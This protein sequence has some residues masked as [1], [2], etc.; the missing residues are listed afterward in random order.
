MRSLQKLSSKFGHE[1]AMVRQT[2]LVFYVIKVHDRKSLTVMESMGVSSSG[3]KASMVITVAPLAL[4]VIW[5]S[6]SLGPGAMKMVTSV[7]PAVDVKAELEPASPRMASLGWKSKSS[8]S[9]LSISRV[10]ASQ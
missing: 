10:S 9:V 1:M 4:K 5:S 6:A 7:L 3:A 2:P 8:W